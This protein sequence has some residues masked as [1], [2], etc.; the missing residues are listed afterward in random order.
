MK[1]RLKAEVRLIP[2]FIPFGLI[3]LRH[4]NTY[5]LVI[6]LICVEITFSYKPKRK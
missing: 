2:A 4:I 3:P 5:E 1:K 6:I